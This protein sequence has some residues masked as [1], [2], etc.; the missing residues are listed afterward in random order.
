MDT[1]GDRMKSYES[2]TTC[3]QLITG[4]PV[5]ARMDGRS[6]HSFT[7]GLSRPYDARLSSLMIAT[8]KYLLEEVDGAVTSYTQ[9]DEITLLIYA[10]IPEQQIFFNGRVFKMVSS[11]AAMAT[12]FFNA[13]LE[14]YIPEKAEQLKGKR[15]FAQ[16][17]A[18]VFNVPN[19]D[20][21]ANHFLWRELDATKNSIS[22]AAQSVY[23]HNELMNKNSGDKMEMLW[24]KGIN[25]ND[26]PTFFKRG[27]YLQR[28]KVTKK[29]SPEELAKL[30]EKHP[31]RVDNDMEFTRQEVMRLNIPPLNRIPFKADTIF[32]RD[33]KIEVEKV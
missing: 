19:E 16:F 30:P 17:D 15:Q 8:S 10:T 1:L 33:E 13:E 31:A 11:L 4:L 22:M 29:F 12:A 20:E 26:Y 6:F 28:R 23:S 27:T 18:R 32:G 21:A 9:S 7:K 3:Q 25:W 5:I 24:Q 14:K 2:Q